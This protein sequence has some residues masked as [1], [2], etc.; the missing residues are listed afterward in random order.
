MLLNGSVD[1]ILASDLPGNAGRSELLTAGNPE[2]LQSIQVLFETQWLCMYVA[3][4]WTH[5]IMVET[6][7]CFCF[8]LV[9]WSPTLY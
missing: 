7:Y 2:G 5:S 3:K 1:Y 6:S 9:T 8:W 4:H